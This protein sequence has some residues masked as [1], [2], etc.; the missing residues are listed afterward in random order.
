MMRLLVGLLAQQLVLVLRKQQVEAASLPTFSP[1]T[2]DLLMGKYLE[3]E[4]MRA[5]IANTQYM[6]IL[7][8]KQA[9]ELTID[10]LKTLIE[11][12]MASP[13]AESGDD[14]LC[15]RLCT[16]IAEND[17]LDDNMCECA[18]RLMQTGQLA[19]YQ[20]AEPCYFYDIEASSADPVAYVREQALECATRGVKCD[21]R[22]GDSKRTPE[23]LSTSLND[24]SN[25]E[26]LLRSFKSRRCEYAV[27]EC[28]EV[29]REGACCAEHSYTE[30]FAVCVH[31]GCQSHAELNDW[32][33][34][35]PR[36]F[37]NFISEITPE[38]D[39]PHSSAA[40]CV[41]SV[42][43]KMAKHELRSHPWPAAEWFEEF[44]D[45]F[46]EDGGYGDDDEY[47]EY[48]DGGDGDGGY[49]DGSEL[50]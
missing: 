3:G 42:A 12:K 9:S 21:M 46:D 5:T 4:Q 1:K 40:V 15:G 14:G 38:D 30:C 48:G 16:R 45:E 23:N 7:L 31:K 32:I 44:E 37:G 49:G 36:G 50:R 18:L 25:L 13:A 20:D 47:D 11:Y 43:A 26:E 27:R 17:L 28:I 39:D 19:D 10:E 34:E 8:R 29:K 41:K 22:Y 35:T 33:M 2:R 6:G 24:F